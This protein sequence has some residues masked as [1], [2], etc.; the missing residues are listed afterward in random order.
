VFEVDHPSTQA[1][2]RAR[3]GEAGVAAGPGL[4]FAPVDFQR[5]GLAEG[6]A[7]AGFDAGRPAFFSW[8]GVAMYL[9]DAAVFQTLGLVAALPAPSEIVFDFMVTPELM[10]PASRLAAEALARNVAALGEPFRSA[11]DPADLVTR[12][13]EAGFSKAETLGAEELNQV[14]F[15]GRTD[16]F[17]LTGSGRLARARV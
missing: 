1:W 14:Y 8:L 16:G 10:S 15:A 7:A 17:R 13:R 2:K 4:T 9:P 11:F 3:L 5:Q 6:L 12:L